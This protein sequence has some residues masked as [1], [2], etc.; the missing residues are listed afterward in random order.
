MSSPSLS[1][2]P[3]T[4]LHKLQLPGRQFWELRQSARSAWWTRE[5]S[6][7]GSTNGKM[8]HFTLLLFTHTH[9]WVQTHTDTIKEQQ[10][11]A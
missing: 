7:K 8:I 9:I 5:K 4:N 3:H 6:E 2:W 10:I 11:A 1:S